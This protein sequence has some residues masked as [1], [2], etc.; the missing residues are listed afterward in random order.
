MSPVYFWYAQF[1][2]PMER[3]EYH[4]NNSNYRNVSE[5]YFTAGRVMQPIKRAVNSVYYLIDEDDIRRR[6]MKD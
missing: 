2:N 3:I 6:L 1:E 5:V 4:P